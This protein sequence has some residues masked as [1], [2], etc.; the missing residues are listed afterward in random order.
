MIRSTPVYIV[1][2]P[3]PDCFNILTWLRL[4]NFF[5]TSTSQRQVIKS[6]DSWKKHKLFR[7]RCMQLFEAGDFVFGELVSCAQPFWVDP[8]PKVHQDKREFVL[9]TFSLWLSFCMC[10]LSRNVPTCYLSAVLKRTVWG[11]S[12]YPMWSQLHMLHSSQWLRSGTLAH[13]LMW[14]YYLCCP[15]GVIKCVSQQQQGIPTTT[16]IVNRV[17][18]P[19][20]SASRHLHMLE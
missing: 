16:H 20:M 19:M 18:T 12:V 13:C 15:W 17:N 2:L 3:R 10:G 6:S 9:P 11:S 4:D 7:R 8:K 5:S 1:S 14:D